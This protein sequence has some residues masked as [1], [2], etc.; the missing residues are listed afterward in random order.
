MWRQQARPRVEKVVAPL[1]M[2]PPNEC[3]HAHDARGCVYVYLYEPRQTLGSVQAVSAGQSLPTPIKRL[4]QHTYLEINAIGKVITHSHVPLQS[5]FLLY[6][7][8][9]SL[10]TKNNEDVIADTSKSSNTSSSSVIW[11]C[12]LVLNAEYW[13]ISYFH[14]RLIVSFIRACCTWSVFWYLWP[15]VQGQDK[16]CQLTNLTFCSGTFSNFFQNYNVVRPDRGE[17]LC[18]SSVY[19]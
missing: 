3:V 13:L 4:L 12:I 8:I 16:Y 19:L 10:C 18:G 9:S 15:R 7:L 2:K 11:F 5:P 17:R 14:L 6:F 1:H